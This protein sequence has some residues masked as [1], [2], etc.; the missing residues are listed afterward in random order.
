MKNL[1]LE[2]LTIN[3]ALSI[4]RKYG[5]KNIA[6][7]NSEQRKEEWKKL[8]KIHHPDAGGSSTAMQE[9]NAAYDTLKA[10]TPSIN[11][12][13]FYSSPQDKTHKA[14]NPYNDYVNNDFKK[15]YKYDDKDNTNKYA[16][17]Y[18]IFSFGGGKYKIPAFSESYVVETTKYDA[19]KK[20]NNLI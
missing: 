2:K 18:Q 4:F 17:T 8:C 13:D 1:I 10:Y 12:S 16:K 9:I 14:K 20:I 6:E 11:Y 7:L 19:T 3:D 15:Y 5:V